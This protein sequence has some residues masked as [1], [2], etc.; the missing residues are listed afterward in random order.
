M[1]RPYFETRFRVDR[2]VDSWPATFVIVTAYATTGTTWPAHENEC[3]DRTL[4]AELRGRTAWVRRV[5][6]YSPTTGHAEPG[7]AALLGFDVACDIGAAY[8][9]DA[10]YLVRG[11]TL[12]VSHCDERRSPVWV[13]R[14]LERV[15]T[16]GT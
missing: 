4:A 13:G 14:F 2:P 11:G 3:A 9:Q 1:H 7:W 5:T 15:D 10:L 8:L 16:P 12:Y 6:G